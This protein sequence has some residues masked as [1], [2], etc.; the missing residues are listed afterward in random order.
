MS[1]FALSYTANMLIL[2]ILYNFCL[3]S[4]YFSYILRYIWKTENY[5][6]IT[7]WCTPRKIPI[8]VKKLVLQTLQF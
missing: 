4:A 3:L 2:I 8:C 7:D 6:Q 1:G 5:V